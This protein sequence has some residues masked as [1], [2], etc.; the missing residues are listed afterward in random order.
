MAD[1][2]FKTSKFQNFLLHIPKSL[3]IPCTL[4]V[5]IF[6]CLS[7]FVWLYQPLLKSYHAACMHHTNL[8]SLHAMHGKI[9]KKNI[10]LKKLTA[11]KNSLIKNHQ[12]EKDPQSCVN[13]AITHLFSTIHEAHLEIVRHTPLNTKEHDWFITFDFCDELQGSFLQF[14]QLFHNLSQKNS[15]LQPLCIKV[16]KNNQ[17]ELSLFMEYTVTVIKEAIP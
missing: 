12:P 6:L 5:F 9:E 16:T 1:F 3:R 15:T 7:W 13:Q 14:I 8:T 2:Y 17:H 4:I 10:K 11:K